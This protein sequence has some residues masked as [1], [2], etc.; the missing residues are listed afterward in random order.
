VPHRAAGSGRSKVRAL[1]SCRVA[2]RQPRE[3]HAPWR[4]R[5]RCRAAHAGAMPTGAPPAPGSVREPPNRGERVTGVRTEALPAHRPRAVC[6]GHRGAH[7]GSPAGARTKGHA[8]GR[9]ESLEKRHVGARPAHGPR[10]ATARRSKPKP[11]G[12]PL[13]AASARRRQGIDAGGAGQRGESCS[14]QWGVHGTHTL[15]ARAAPSGRC[16]PAPNFSIP[17]YHQ[18]LSGLPRADSGPVRATVS[19]PW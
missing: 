16:C 2:A 6:A 19:G 10:H 12:V 18:A 13:G 14:P 7:D 17:P 11:G 9:Q 8:S 3:D 4:R 15:Y 5:S 1:V